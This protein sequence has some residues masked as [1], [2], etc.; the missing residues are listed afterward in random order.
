MKILIMTLLISVPLSMF[1]YII[2]Y[3][4]R[5]G[6]KGPII[7]CTLP[8]ECYQAQQQLELDLIRIQKFGK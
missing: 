7:T 5:E 2:N 8:G 3:D 1:A 4:M 6:S